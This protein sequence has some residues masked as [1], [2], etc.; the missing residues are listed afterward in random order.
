MLSNVYAGDGRW[1]DVE[2]MRDYITTAGAEKMPG[3]S[4]IGSY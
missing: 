4:R 2:K 3:L 1:V